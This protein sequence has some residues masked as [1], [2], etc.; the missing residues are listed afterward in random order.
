MHRTFVNLPFYQMEYMDKILGVELSHKFAPI[1]I[2]EKVALNKKQTIDALTD[3]K[4]DC[5]EAIILSTCNRLSIYAY[6]SQLQP[7]V[8]FFNRMGISRQYL[9]I[10]PDTDISISNLFNTAAGLESQAVGEHQIL[11]QIKQALDLGRQAKSTGPVLDELVRQAIHTG[12]RVRLETK[13]GKYSASLAT[14]GFELIEKHGYHLPDSN[15]LVIGTGNMANLVATIL[16]RTKVKKL[17][18]SSHEMDRAEK[19][20]KEW[21]GEAIELKDLFAIFSTTDIVIGGTQGEINILSEQELQNSKCKR[22]EFA[23]G[24]GN[25]KLFIDFGVPRNFNPSLKLHPNIDLYDLDDIK[26]LT[27]EGLLK[28]YNEIPQ[29]HDIINQKVKHFSEWLK[30][31]KVAPILEAYWHNLDEI[32]M[33]ELKWLLPK[34]GNISE[35]QKELIMR[36]THRMMRKITKS[37]I[38]GIKRIADN[39]HID[40]NP[41]HTVQDIFD[42]NDVQ[43]FVPKKKIV[44]GTRGSKLALTQTQMMIEELKKHEPQYEFITKVI[45]TNGDDGNINVVGAFTT[46]IQKHL[47]NGDIDLAVHSFKD[48]PVENIEGLKI[49]A[50]TEREPAND[51]LISKNNLRLEEL[52]TNAIVG[53]GSLRRDI[54]LRMLRPDIQIKHIQG[55][56]DTRI[57]KMEEGEYDAIVLAAAGLKRLEMLHLA[58][59]VFTLDEMLPAAGQG[60][61]AIETRDEKNYVSDLVSMLNHE[62]TR[63]A[64]KAERHFLISLGGGCNYPIAVFSELKK[65]DIIIKGFYATD[66]GSSVVKEMLRAPQSQYMRISGEMAALVKQKCGT[67]TKP[68]F[69][70][71]ASE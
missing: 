26:K 31:R 30:H 55:N 56:V 13:I 50:V 62:P 6:T 11:G 8:D 52:P 64:T 39:I 47:L 23:L 10:L 68:V 45:R 38:Q 44:V 29:A 66:D 18:V 25:K 1:S 19:M 57:K 24:T 58:T 15:L 49:C 3:L 20:A 40:Q 9:N 16:D 60:A 2:R 61:L 14:V 28:R 7:L 41:L 54:Q 5:K 21:G 27:Y 42:V 70:E 22:A 46:A 59:Q 35:Q 69:R 71:S 51:V 67:E 65:N 17:Y 4:K 34:L 12:K 43:I 53:T 32:K 33:E 48:L 63:I 37:P 36:F